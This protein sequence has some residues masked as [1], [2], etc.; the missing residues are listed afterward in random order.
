MTTLPQT[1]EEI[2]KTSYSHGLEAIYALENIDIKSVRRIENPS[3]SVYRKNEHKKAI[4]LSIQEEFDFGQEFRRWIPSF[5]KKEPIHVLE[6]SKH[7]E[8]CLIEN[9]K[10][11]LGDLI[12][13]NL[14]D[15]VFLRGMG[16]GHIEEI[17]QKLTDYLNG[18]NLDKSLQIDFSSW[19]KTLTAAYDRKKVFVVLEL[20]DLCD[21]FSLTPGENVEVRKLTLEK[22]QEWIEEILKKITN[23]IQKKSIQ[24]DMQQIFNA[25]F[26]SWIR[27]RKGFVTHD[28]LKERM[29]QMS[30]NPR[31]CF[32]ALNFF[33][34]VFFEKQS[35]FNYFLQEVDNNVYCCDLLDSSNYKKVFLK[36]MS[37]FYKPSVYYPLNELIRLLE[38]E[39]AKSWT[40]FADGY[41]EKILRLS[42]S[43]QIIK[44]NLGCLE[45]HLR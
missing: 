42:P 25:F 2:Y 15:F 19:L 4:S 37:Y 23:P 34:N 44:N 16:Q 6:I 9:G 1:F 11:T 21:I 39:F 36:T 43:F 20:Y 27:Q 41:I 40:G 31:M 10:S 29:Q 5:I 14:K 26:K 7:A 30:T 22:R 33:Q 24:H 8:K 17:N 45:I 38:K 18:Q 28:E 12:G 32:S 3:K 35:F 13:I